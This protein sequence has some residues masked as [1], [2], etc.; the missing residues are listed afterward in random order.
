MSRLLLA[1]FD[2]GGGQ[3]FLMFGKLVVCVGDAGID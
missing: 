2:D 3:V 1:F